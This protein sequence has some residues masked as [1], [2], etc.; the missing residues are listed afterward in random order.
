MVCLLVFF[1]SWWKMVQSCRWVQPQQH[2][3]LHRQ[4]VLVRLTSS[5]SLVNLCVYDDELDREDM[6]NTAGCLSAGTGDWASGR[7]DVPGS[8]PLDVPL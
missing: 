6:P 8:V 1:L 4:Q 3:W 7:V 5:A 2:V